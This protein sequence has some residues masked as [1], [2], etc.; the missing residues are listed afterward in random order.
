MLTIDG[1]LGEGGGQVLRTAIA[2]AALT[3]QGLHIHSIRAGRRKPGLMR[4]HLAAVNA[5]ATI[6]G[7]ELDG[8]SIGATRLGFHPGPVRPGDYRFAIGTAGSTT[9]LLQTVLPLLMTANGPST[10]TLEGGTH[11]PL[12]PPFECI[13][14]AF[15]PLIN[16]MGPTVTATLERPGFY[17]A[18]GGRITVAI[19]PCARLRPLHVPERGPIRTQTALALVCGLSGQIA[20]REL[21][22][23]AAELGWS[24]D[25]LQIRQ[26]NAAHGPGNVLSLIVQS[27]NITDV[28]TAFGEKGIPAERVAMDAVHQVR[29]Y[30]ASNAAAGEYL[31]DQLQLPLALAGGEFTGGPPS[32]HARTNAQ[33]IRTVLGVDV[34]ARETEDGHWRHEVAAV[35]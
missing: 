20:R 21:D 5:V 4:Q 28:F 2:L 19:Q 6:S 24:G 3:G 9:L 13:A 35:R 27:E 22:V 1:A 18:G 33:V 16:R 14:Q 11:N 26:L 17:P 8:A 10:L 32:R 15:L 25:A 34:T 23:V 29:R 12:A 7:G 30:L 31:T